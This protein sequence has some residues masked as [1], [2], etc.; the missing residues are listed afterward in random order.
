MNITGLVFLT[1]PFLLAL[2][3]DRTHRD[4][5]PKVLWGFGLLMIVL[6]GVLVAVLPNAGRLYYC[7]PLCAAGYDPVAIPLSALIVL[8]VVQGL[9]A[10]RSPTWVTTLVGGIVGYGAMLPFF[11]IS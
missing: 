3:W 11:W 6:G 10:F 2:V 5:G 1:V 7:G 9:R 4:R 8:L